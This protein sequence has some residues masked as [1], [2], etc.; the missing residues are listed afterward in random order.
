MFVLSRGVEDDS[1]T[2]PKGKRDYICLVDK[3]LII[4]DEDKTSTTQMA[5][6]DNDLFKK[7]VGSNRAMYGRLQYIVLIGTAGPLLK[8]SAMSI[9]P[10]SDLQEVFP[11]ME[12]R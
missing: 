9:T 12:V 11:A 10:G 4:A 1:I 2:L 3:M 5:E 6:A 8:L 7:H